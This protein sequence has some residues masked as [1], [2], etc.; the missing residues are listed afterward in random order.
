MIPCK[1][2]LWVHTIKSNKLVSTI[3]NSEIINREVSQNQHIHE[4]LKLKTKTSFMHFTKHMTYNP[5][6][7]DDKKIVDSDHNNNVIHKQQHIERGKEGMLLYDIY[8][9]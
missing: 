4:F 1:D 2:H 9:Q 5:Y 3:D 7:E 8:L 6:G